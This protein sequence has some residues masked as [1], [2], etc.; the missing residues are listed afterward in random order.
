MLSVWKKAGH[1]CTIG[2]DGVLARI[3]VPLSRSCESVVSFHDSSARGWPGNRYFSRYR[4]HVSEAGG[5][6]AFSAR[7]SLPPLR[8]AVRLFLPQASPTPTLLRNVT[9][10]RRIRRRH[11]S[12]LWLMAFNLDH[13]H[14]LGLPVPGISRIFSLAFFPPP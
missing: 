9:R 13:R 2:I 8:P 7:V 12:F 5:T 3:S 11:L 10:A 4:G 1:I 6:S 14:G